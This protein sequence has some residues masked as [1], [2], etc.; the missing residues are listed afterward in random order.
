MPKRETTEEDWEE[1]ERYGAD[2]GHWEI[3]RYHWYP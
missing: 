2:W 3:D 1:K